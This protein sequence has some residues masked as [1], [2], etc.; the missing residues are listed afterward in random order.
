MKTVILHKTRRLL[1]YLLLL[2]FFF[3][4][5]L[6]KIVGSSN[7]P[8]LN[9]HTLSENVCSSCLQHKRKW[10]DFSFALFL[11]AENDIKFEIVV[12]SVKYIYIHVFFAL[13]EEKKNYIPIVFRKKTILPI[14]GWQTHKDR[15]YITIARFSCYYYF[16]FLLFLL[17]PTMT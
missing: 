12:V 9:F 3:T 2:F 5:R 17:F 10:G 8:S 7:E 6:S 4:F 15:I 13:Y 1:H 11:H 16:F 14:S